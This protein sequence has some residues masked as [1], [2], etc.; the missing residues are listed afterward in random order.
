[1]LVRD[2]SVGLNP[3]PHGWVAA[4]Q[5]SVP[6]AAGRG[7]L[8]NTTWTDETRLQGVQPPER[9]ACGPSLHSK[10]LATISHCADCPPG[11]FMLFLYPRLPVPG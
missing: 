8:S 10:V 7:S 6:G 5:A 4:A 11:P 3:H 9:A 1:M 2:G